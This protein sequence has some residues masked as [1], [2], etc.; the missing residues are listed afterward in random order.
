MHVVHFT[1]S[2]TR[3]YLSLPIQSQVIELIIHEKSN[4]TGYGY[5][6]SEGNIHRVPRDD[7]CKVCLS[8]GVAQFQGCFF[9]T[10]APP[11]EPESSPGR[12]LESQGVQ[13]STPP[14][15]DRRTSVS[16]SRRSHQLI[17]PLEGT[18]STVESKFCQSSSGHEDAQ[19]RRTSTTLY[20]VRAPLREVSTRAASPQVHRLRR[21]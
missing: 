3:K 12:G 1:M 7:S 15:V 16:K 20:Q 8:T 11:R 14:N 2:N 13:P 9:H 18:E 19:I 5:P 10:C 21:R 4:T 17:Q 6:K